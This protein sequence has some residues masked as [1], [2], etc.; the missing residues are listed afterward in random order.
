MASGNDSKGEGR[1]WGWI[2][3]NGNA[4]QH[5]I[6]IKWLQKTYPTAAQEEKIKAI[7]LP[8]IQICP[9]IGTAT[10]KNYLLKEESPHK[11]IL[12]VLRELSENR[13]AMD[14]VD[15]HSFIRDFPFLT[16]PHKEWVSSNVSKIVAFL[17]ECNISLC[18]FMRDLDTAPQ[19]K[20]YIDNNQ[21]IKSA[22]AILRRFLCKP[23]VGSW[24]QDLAL[25]AAKL[26][27][28]ERKRLEEFDKLFSGETQLSMGLLRTFLNL[29]GDKR[30][31][32]EVIMSNSALRTKM[33]AC[34]I[35]EY[36]WFHM[37]E[38]RRNVISALPEEKIEEF[39]DKA[40]EISQAMGDGLLIHETP[41]EDCD[42]ATGLGIDEIFDAVNESS[43]NKVFNAAPKLDIDK[44]DDA[45]NK[46][47]INDI[48]DYFL[49]KYIDSHITK[50]ASD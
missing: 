50:K 18:L 8:I 45:A 11:Q 37:N 49:L 30:S 41:Q 43:I 22:I 33:D 23:T 14:K 29:E 36:L 34:G 40:C 26:S 9:D 38:S 47:G 15:V 17:K 27:N 16:E 13:C 20:Y 19:S 7:L 10:L 4:L 21:V 32:V 6:F 39:M 31:N 28:A 42:A 2:P 12:E 35:E 24:E 3:C 46:L 5:K 48:S 1:P 25:Y 44:I